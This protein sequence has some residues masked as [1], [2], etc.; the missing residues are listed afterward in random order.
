MFGKAI[1][2]QD[3]TARVEAARAF[4]R[5]L[6]AA[7][8]D[9]PEHEDLRASYRR[10]ARELAEAEAALADVVAESGEVAAGAAQ[11]DAGSCAAAID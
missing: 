9:Q 4:E 10:A 5:G 11:A 8:R 2:L 6:A 3:A 7:L 1:R